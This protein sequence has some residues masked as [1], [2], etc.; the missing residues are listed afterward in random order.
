MLGCDPKYVVVKQYFEGGLRIVNLFAFEQA[1]KITWIRRM[2][3]D[4]IK[5]QLFI[6]KKYIYISMSTLSSCG[7]D[8]IKN[9]VTSL[10]MNF[11]RTC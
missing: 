4:D 10:K 8:Y 1:L 5:W 7:S 2:L 3:Q 6:K 9:I 11:G